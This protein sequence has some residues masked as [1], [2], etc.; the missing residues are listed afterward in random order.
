MEYIWDS[1]DI[2]IVQAHLGSFGA[3]AICSESTIFTF[4]L[5]LIIFSHFFFFFFLHRLM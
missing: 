4:L 2:V 5:L 1:F 3:I